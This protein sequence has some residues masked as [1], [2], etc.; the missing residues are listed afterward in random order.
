MRTAPANYLIKASSLP[1]KHR[2]LTLIEVV[3]SM[4]VA[5]LAL[6]GITSALLIANRA[7]DSS[8]GTSTQTTDA[9]VVVDLI[10]A[11][12]NH[13]LSFSEQTVNAVTFDVPDRDGDG[14]NETIRYVWSGT[15]GDPLTYIN[16][17]GNEIPI[18]T[19]VKQFQLSYLTRPIVP[20]VAPET[21]GLLTLSYYDPMYG[22]A[23]GYGIDQS[24]W[25]AQYFKPTLPTNTVSWNISYIYLALCQEHIGRIF[26]LQIQSASARQVPSGQVLEQQLYYTDSLPAGAYYWCAFTM[27]GTSSLG[28]DDGTCLVLSQPFDTIGTRLLYIENGSSMP[29]NSHWTTT[30]DAGLTWTTPVNN[31]DMLYYIDGTITTKGPVKW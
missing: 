24:H 25:C 18:I 16:N 13:A 19:K 9:R 14:N 3:A 20:P 23:K 11:N 29:Q 26:R 7:T 17:A 30:A 10:T 1:A 5:A 22:T 4:S 12:L 28:P 6:G 31:L 27:S 15:A 2:G 21:I 8:T